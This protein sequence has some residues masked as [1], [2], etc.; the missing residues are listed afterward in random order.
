MRQ[1]LE[2]RMWMKDNRIRA[3]SSQSGCHDKG[4]EGDPEEPAT[5][6]GARSRPS[7]KEA[8]RVGQM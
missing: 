1:A 5:E 3:V 6:A 8:K 7:E 2:S 4:H